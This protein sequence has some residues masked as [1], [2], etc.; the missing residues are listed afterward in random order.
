[1]GC[2]TTYDGMSATW[3]KCKLSR[4]SSGTLASGT[5]NYT[6]TYNAFGQRVAKTYSYLAGTSGL[7]PVQAA[8]GFC[9]PARK[10]PGI[11]S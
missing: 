3:S 4:L 2:P 6:Y 8:L 10:E 11:D 1:M 7:N 5:S 9:S